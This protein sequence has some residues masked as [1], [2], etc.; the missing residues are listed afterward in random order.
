MK[1]QL[2]FE[3]G[4]KDEI[5][6]KIEYLVKRFRSVCNGTPLQG[7]EREEYFL[8]WESSVQSEYSKRQ[9]REIMQDQE[10]VVV[11]KAL[12]VGCLQLL[13]EDLDKMNI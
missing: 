4:E 2:I 13:K 6:D 7:K 10:F 8:A 3:K 1:H 11:D 5:L 9:I 12:Y